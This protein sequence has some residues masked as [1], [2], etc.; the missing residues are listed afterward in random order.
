MLWT[1]WASAV[2]PWCWHFLE[3]VQLLSNQCTSTMTKL[4]LS[5]SC[6]IPCVPP[7]SQ[8]FTSLPVTSQ[9]P[10][11]LTDLPTHGPAIIL[12]NFR[13]Y[14]EWTPKPKILSSDPL[15]IPPH[16]E[17]RPHYFLEFLYSGV[18]TPVSYSP[19]VAS[20]SLPLLSFGFVEASCSL[21]SL[22]VFSHLSSSTLHT[23]ILL[24]SQATISV[25]LTV[26]FG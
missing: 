11:L 21:G 15:T 10:W 24:R 12:A 3:S 9:R 4:H 20:F 1:L 5:F 14:G 23:C 17:P 25:T 7:L 19:T 8:S 16:Q 18:S 13:P 26:S 22:S 2:Y 6:S